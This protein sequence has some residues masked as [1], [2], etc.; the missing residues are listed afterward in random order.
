MAATIARSKPLVSAEAFLR[1]YAD[2]PGVELV[3]GKIERYPM[4]QAEHGIVMLEAG[5][6]FREHVKKRDL[7]W[8]MV[9]DTLIRTK[10]EPASLRG[11]D[12][13]Y[14]SY[15]RWPKKSG[16]PKGILEI[17]PELVVEVISPSDRWAK[18]LSKISEYLEAGVRVVIVLDPETESASIHRQ[19]ELHQLA[20][21]G[22]V[23]TLPDVLPGFSVPVKKFFE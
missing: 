18:V 14:L 23:V 12:V 8:V 1:K 6:I 16:R 11:A 4:P 7:G 22:D 15:K 13:A 3:K 9:G 21:N 20:H 17:P 19:D 5:V 10:S 2:E